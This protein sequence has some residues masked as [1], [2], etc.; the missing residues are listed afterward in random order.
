MAATLRGGTRVAA[1]VARRACAARSRCLSTQ[2]ADA[3]DDAIFPPLTSLHEDE[4]MMRDAAANFAANEVMPRVTA[5]DDASEMDPELLTGLFDNGFMGVEIDDAHGGSGSSFTAA[6]LVIE[7]LAKADP[8]VA[9]SVDIHNTIINNC[10]SMWASP[11]LQREWLPRLATDTLGAFALSE[12]SSGSDAFALKSTAT[13][14]GTD[15]ILNGEKMWISNSLEAVRAR[16]ALFS[17]FR[18]I[19]PAARATAWHASS[20]ILSFFFSRVVRASSW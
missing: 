3:A 4:Q 20:A 18:A 17:F 14:D 15:Y 11:E 16:A 19:Q 7:E 9:V 2:H 12:A 8:S 1:R 5:M 13:R 6:C 10:F